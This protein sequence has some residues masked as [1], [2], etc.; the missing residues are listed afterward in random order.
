M[1]KSLVDWETSYR[2]S[3]K[4]NQNSQSVEEDVSAGESFDLKRREDVSSFEKAKAHKSSM[5][6][7]ISE[8]IVI[9]SARR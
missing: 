5:E 2:E 4:H 1:L 3:A 9:F 8:V 7:S 6:S